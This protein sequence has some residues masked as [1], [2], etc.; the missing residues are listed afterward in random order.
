[1]T[2]TSKQL[3]LEEYLKY[4][5]GT[6]IQYELVAGELVAM[7]PESPKNVQIALFLLVQF[8][9]FVPIKRLSNKAEIIISGFRATARILDLVVLTDE[10]A[11]VL[12]GLKNKTLPGSIIMFL[13]VDESRVSSVTHYIKA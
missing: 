6:D 11:S 7:P 2:T 10:L 5:D 3:T 13:A 1:M 8:L 9:K 4:D 12:Q